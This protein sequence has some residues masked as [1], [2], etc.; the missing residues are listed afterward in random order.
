MWVQLQAK[1]FN[2]D[3]AYGLLHLGDMKGMLL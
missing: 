1:P 2:K 3:L